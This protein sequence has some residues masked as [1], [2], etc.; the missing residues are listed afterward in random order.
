MSL[1]LIQ[2]QL[3]FSNKSDVKP[4]W[5]TVEWSLEQYGATIRLTSKLRHLS[6]SRMWQLTGGG[7]S[8]QEQKQYFLQQMEE[9]KNDLIT[10]LEFI[11][12]ATRGDL[13]DDIDGVEI[14]WVKPPLQ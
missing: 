12:M 7:E 14:K 11:Y 8:I 4:F 13:D 6:T 1:L 3:Q 2:K 9:A 10:R 5:D